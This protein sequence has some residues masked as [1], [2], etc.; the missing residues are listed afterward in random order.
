MAVAK[1]MENGATSVICAST[2]NTLAS[3]AAYAAAFNLKAI[4]CHTDRENSTREIGT[5]DDT[6]C[7]S[8][9][10]RWEF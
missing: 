4:I 6:R 8:R 10:S 1:A 2:G 5:S 3:A 9:P 7:R